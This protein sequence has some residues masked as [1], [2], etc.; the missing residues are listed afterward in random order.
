YEYRAR[1][2]EPDRHIAE[3][4]D[5]THH[6]ID[7]DHRHHVADADIPRGADAVALGDGGDDFVGAHVQR[8]QAV[9]IGVDHHG[10]RASA[11]RWGGGNAWK[12]REEGPDAEQGGILEVFQSQ[13]A[14]LVAED[15]LA[16]RYTSGIKPHDKWRDRS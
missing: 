14:G 13:L 2:V 7:R 12:G 5:I 15:Q 11:E 1:S 16:D 10:A 6:G 8:A 3:F 4:A 9:G